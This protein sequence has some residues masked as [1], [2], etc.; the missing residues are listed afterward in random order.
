LHALHLTTRPLQ[1]RL[2]EEGTSFS[3]L[4]AEVRRERAMELM[5]RS[6]MSNSA[7][8]VTLGFEDASAFSRAF[9]TWTGQSPRDYR[10]HLWDES[11]LP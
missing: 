4:L 6:H 1:R 7:I 10:R 5:A 8:A 9:K 3:T 11:A 2:D